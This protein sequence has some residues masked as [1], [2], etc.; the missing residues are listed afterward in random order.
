MAAAVSGGGK[1][2]DPKDPE[3]RQAV[4][5][6]FE[7]I[8][9]ESADLEPEAFAAQAAQFAGATGIVPERL[10]TRVSAGLRSEDANTQADA[11]RLLKAMTDAALGVQSAGFNPNL[12][13]QQLSGSCCVSY[14][15]ASL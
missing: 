4:E 9:S 11:A 1:A 3:H 13:N 5:E 12:E 15:T 6:G 7:T 10:V 14:R 8:L 2:L